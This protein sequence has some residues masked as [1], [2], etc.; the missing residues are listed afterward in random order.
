MMLF[1]RTTVTLDR[2]L[3]QILRENAVRT[4][5]PFKRLLNEA[6]RSGLAANSA[7]DVAKPFV[8]KSRKMGL[9]A[10]LD[11]RAFSKLGDDLEA[12]AFVELTRE[13]QKAKR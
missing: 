7:A 9:R 8:V 11:P 12:A 6:I 10:G 13:L 5:R 3:E 2:D 1:V 4:R